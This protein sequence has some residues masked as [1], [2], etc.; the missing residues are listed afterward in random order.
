[1]DFTTREIGDAEL[2]EK[3]TIE[4]HGPDLPPEYCRYKDEGCEY[5]VSCL[6]CPFPQCL[7]DEPR[8]RQRWMKGLR[9][10]EINR[11]FRD[12]RRVKELA[13]M[14]GVS[15]RTIQRA[16]K[17]TLPATPAKPEATTGE[18]GKVEQRRTNG[19]D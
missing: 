6:G 5:A 2:E 14:F 10:K 1:M 12:G 4:P 8:G 15:L 13:L 17:S 9:N 18:T 19:N 11:L 7:Y 3:E 16:L